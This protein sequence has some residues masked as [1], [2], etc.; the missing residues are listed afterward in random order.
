[1]DL[2]NLM[3]RLTLDTSEYESSMEQ[4]ESKGSAFG[5]AMTGIAEGIKD[6]LTVAGVVAV[7]DKISS[8]ISQAVRMTASYADTV[9]KG[10]RS[11]QISSEA[12]QQ[13]DYALS[14]SGANISDISR[15]ISNLNKTIAGMEVGENVTAALESLQIDPKTYK[16]TESLLSDVLFS[17]AQ[18]DST[19]ERGALT[20]ALFGRGAGQRLNALLDSGV[21]GIQDLLEGAREL[22]LIMSGEDI[23]KG[24]AYGDALDSMNSAVDALKQ[25]IF[26][27]LFPLL[28]DA[29]NMIT[30]IVAFF[31]GRTQEK[32]ID[33][34]FSDIDD[35][36]KEAFSE[37]DNNEAKVSSL[38]DT[39]VSMSDSTGTAAGNLQ[40]W[41]SVAEQL[42][43]LC[44]NLASQIDLVNGKIK[45]QGDELKQTAEEWF[46]N[47]RAQAVAQALQD[48]QNV[49]AEQASKVVEKQIDL[50]D[51]QTSATA[52]RSIAEKNLN[53]VLQELGLSE[54][55]G[56]RPEDIAS[57]NYLELMYLIDQ[58]NQENLTDQQFEK[59]DVA[60]DALNDFQELQSE[61]E[62]IQT[63]I[64][65]MNTDLADAQAKYQEY[66]NAANQY[67]T[68]LQSQ[69][70]GIPRNIN[71]AVNFR[72]YGLRG[73]NDTGLGAVFDNSF[74]H[75]SGLN[76]VPYDGYVAN[77]HRGETILNQAQARQWRNEDGGSVGGI[78]SQEL[79]SAVA[80]AVRAAMAGVSINMN[81]ERVGD[82][83]TER[84]SSNL[85]TQVRARRY[86][87]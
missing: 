61:I 49:L 12:Y 66:A 64:E 30:Q 56:Y 54:T 14:Q 23:E 62:T 31:N 40:L 82:V 77:L 44:P 57:K 69:I 60:T 5:E 24:V 17:L 19:P 68:G 76:Y 43:T 34:W 80:N 4:A 42:I 8:A 51:K 59:I 13:W 15:G 6:A 22:G 87:I 18:M 86:G 10:S 37:T 32:G 52:K 27:G 75:A 79:A 41:Q 84:V 38:I 50:I 71:V 47:A 36:M 25:N 74:M 58:L 45:A 39:L 7:I 29:A 1:M 48:K 3:A 55:E 9:D 21:D 73:I 28:T 81:G 85:A 83:V 11:L 26:I 20:E 67:L 65:T 70:A 33:E 72:T 78:N 16:N 35:S 2:F 46:N 63:D 53:E